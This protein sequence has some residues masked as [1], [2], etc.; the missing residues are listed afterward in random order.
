[1]PER[2]AGLLG[3]L[4]RSGDEA[5][6]ETLRERLGRMLEERFGGG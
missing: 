5:L 6:G 1:M 4:R 3:L 2:V